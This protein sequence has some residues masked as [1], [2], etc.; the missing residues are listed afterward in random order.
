ME[1]KIA[2]E[3]QQALLLA[4]SKLT[5]EQRLDA[6]LAHNRLVAKL[7]ESGQQAQGVAERRSQ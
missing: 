4:A 6:F 5:F 7:K 3:S 1:S 2:E